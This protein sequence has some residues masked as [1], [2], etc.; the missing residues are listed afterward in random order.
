MHASPTAVLYVRNF[1]F[2]VEDSLVSTVGLLSGV[3]VA[4]VGRSD[5]IITGTV[6][7]FVEAFSMGAGSFLSEYLS[8]EYADARRANLGRAIVGAIIMFFSYFIAGFVPLLPYALMF[9]AD[10]FS[11]SIAASLVT[12]FLLG[13]WGGHMSGLGSLSRGLRMFF[14][15]GFAILLGVIVGNMFR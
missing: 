7:I 12:L 4:G 10:P 8:E 6:L 9:V 3:A 14:I 15:G 1:I 11:T 2:G 5:I 13:A